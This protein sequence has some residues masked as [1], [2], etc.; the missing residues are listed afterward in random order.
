MGSAMNVRSLAGVP[1]A[2]RKCASRTVLT[3][4]NPAGSGILSFSRNSFFKP[5]WTGLAMGGLEH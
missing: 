3:S 1:P 2:S 4:G 5:V